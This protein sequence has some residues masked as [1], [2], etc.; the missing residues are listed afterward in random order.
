MRCLPDVNDL[1]S[2]SF[3]TTGH[4]DTTYQSGTENRRG[5]AQFMQA[6]AACRAKAHFTA[7]TGRGP[8]TSHVNSSMLKRWFTNRDV[9]EAYR[10]CGRSASTSSP[11][12]NSTS[13]SYTGPTSY[14]RGGPCGASTASMI[15]AQ[16]ALGLQ[17]CG[18]PPLARPSNST[19]GRG[20]ERRLSISRQTGS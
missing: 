5:Y 4:F 13:S 1:I 15:S 16:S 7:V 3:C 17:V 8:N 10:K 6:V 12:I 20:S 2:A 11:T 18:L 9:K 19:D 14:F